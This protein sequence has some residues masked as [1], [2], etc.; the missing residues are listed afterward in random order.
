MI[1]FNYEL[2][3]R[4]PHEAQHR[5]WA[6][7]CGRVEGFE[8]GDINFIFCD[9]AYLLKINQEY[10]GHDYYTDIITFDYVVGKMLS[11]DVF[12][13]IDR[14]TENARTYR[15]SFEEEL[16]RVMAHGL[17]HL[18]GY[19]DKSDQEKQLMR[20]KEDEKLKMFHVER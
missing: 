7:T 14:V 4:L 3:F 5:V 16:K 10:L 17:L 13:S 11:G 12:I 15:V 1:H 20:K 8:I 19:K 2:N 18:M 6:E 9:D